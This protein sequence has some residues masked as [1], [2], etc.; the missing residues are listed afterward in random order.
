M[1][2][3]SSCKWIAVAVLVLAGAARSA[4]ATTQTVF[5]G[6]LNASSTVATPLVGGDTLLLDTIVTTEVGAL[7]QTV[8][9][10]LGA[11][12]ASV[13]GF[14]AW[15]ATEATGIGPR[16]I[17]VNIEIFD[18]ANNLVV[19]DTFAGVLAS[20]AH[21]TITS[22]IGPGTYRA[23]VTGNAIRDS[24]LDLSL[25]FV[26]VPEP[27]TSALLLSGLGFLGMLA[28]RSAKASA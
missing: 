24:V 14:A 10:T 7:L 3:I 2:L 27:A 12:V 11:D 23:V 17:G 8:T 18:A 28:R 22:A 19:S 4:D 9:F 15:E 5:F 21:S 6:Q 1:N 16:L 20:F 13:V 26:P 25:S